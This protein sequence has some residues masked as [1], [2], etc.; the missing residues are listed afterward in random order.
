MTLDRE[1]LKKLLQEKGVKSVDDF[2]AFMREVSKGV[3]EMFLE[4]QLIDQLGLEK[5]D[6]KRK[7]TDNARNGYT[8]RT[9]ES[10][11]AGID[12]AVP[13]DRKSGFGPQIIWQKLRLLGIQ[14][15]IWNPKRRIYVV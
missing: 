8:V 3:V 1:E 4:G 14:G 15:A 2:S 5:Y 10:E 7:A 6:Q 11:F 13:Q 9:A 12:L